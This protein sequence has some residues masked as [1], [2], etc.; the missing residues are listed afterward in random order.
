[1]RVDGFINL[2]RSFP[3]L[4]GGLNNLLFTENGGLYNE[5]CFDVQLLALKTRAG[6]NKRKWL[7]RPASKAMT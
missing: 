3:M 1:M 5:S 4:Q 7:Y 2:E 6:E